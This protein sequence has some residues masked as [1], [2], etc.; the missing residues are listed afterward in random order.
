MLSC[1]ACNV[2]SMLMPSLLCVCLRL[3]FSWADGIRC[4][5]APYVLHLRYE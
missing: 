4:T 1:R 3:W 5:T 2:V